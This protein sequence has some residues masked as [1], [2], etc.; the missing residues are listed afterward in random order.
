MKILKVLFLALTLT[1]V[2]NI[3]TNAQ[4]KAAAATSKVNK[5]TVLWY[6]GDQMVAERVA[7]M[8]TGVA[9][10]YKLFDEVSVIIWGPSAKLV[11]E[12]KEIQA[13]VK[14]MMDLG[15]KVNACVT[16][17]NMYGVTD[18][19]KALGIN[20]DIMGMPLTNALKADDTAVLTF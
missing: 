20:V 18:Q 8:Y 3:V 19:L 6:S 5:L 14:E 11:A 1:F 10:Q 9:K 13:K 15:I 16:C 17:A 7:L 2:S 12:N 4:E